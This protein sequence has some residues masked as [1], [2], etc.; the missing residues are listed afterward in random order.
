MM[1]NRSAC[2]VGVMLALANVATAED[3]PATAAKPAPAS[4]D[5]AA[6]DRQTPAALRDAV[7]RV[8]PSLVVIETVAGVTPGRAA[9]LRNPGEGPTTGLIV[10]ADGC[11]VTSTFNLI[12]NPRVITVVL[13]DKSR[14]I[15][16]LLGRDETRKI[17][18]LK[19]DDV[20]DLPV[21]KL[22][23]RSGVQTGQ[24]TVSVGVGY[25]DTEPAVSVGIVSGLNR[26]GG[27]AVQTDANISPVNYGGPLIDIEGR[28]IGICVPLSP[29]GRDVASGTEWYD[30]GIGFA[31]PLDGAETLIAALRSGTVVRPGVL[32]VQIAPTEDRTPGALIG[33][34]AKDS[35]AG[36]AGMKAGDRVIV[37]DKEPAID[38]TQLRTILS[39]HVA[40]DRIELQY[41]RDKEIKTI[42][43]E[44]APAPSGPQEQPPP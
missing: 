2:L 5:H 43:V 11:I 13:A 30:S 15:A 29:G 42:K 32:G 44:L 31:I 19:L 34:V 33:A 10:S 14:H 4:S 18:L 12:S 28:V 27:R 36:K 40:G 37:C 1:T 20:H 17:C 8:R 21:P 16:K 6:G 41:K 7:A 26:V 38:A 35:P 39:R 9:G 24:W 25:G 23:P 3:A 22:A